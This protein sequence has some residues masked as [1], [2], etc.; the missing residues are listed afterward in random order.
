M[1]RNMT[2]FIPQNDELVE[3]KEIVDRTERAEAVK[4]KRSGPIMHRPSDSQ[5]PD[6]LMSLLALSVNDS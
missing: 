3:M 6:W 2:N 1:Y 5:I 4:V